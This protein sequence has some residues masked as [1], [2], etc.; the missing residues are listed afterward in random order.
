M[1][2]PRTW[3]AMLAL[4]TA[5]R[6]GTHTERCVPSP[7]GSARM[8]NAEEATPSAWQSARSGRLCTRST[9][10]QNLG[11]D[12][13]RA[14]LEAWA[15]RN[16]VTLIAVHEDH[17]VS[18][19]TQL[20]ERPGLL[21]A[22]EGLTTHDAGLLVAAK[23]DRFARDVVVASLIERAAADAGAIVRTADGSS[24]A[25][26]PEGVMMRGI[27][28]VFAQYEREVIKAR[29]RAALAVKK[30]RGERV[31]EI[32]FG[33]RLSEDGVHLEEDAAEQAILALVR[34]LHSEGR[35]Q[36]GIAAELAARGLLSRVGRPFGKTQIARMLCSR[37]GGDP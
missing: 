3:N 18:G 11:P 4:V 36:R 2:E 17:G 19:A 13:Q 7:Q 26:G 32:P 37:C 21:A 35:S 9:D 28:D 1:D 10:D 27:V 12:A 16:G 20:F 25:V 5:S 31:G 33:Y 8:R 23:R 29:T 6:E 30:T 34:A 22:V 24:D 15:T 14:A